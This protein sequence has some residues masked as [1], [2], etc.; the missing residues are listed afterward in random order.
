MCLIVYLNMGFALNELWKTG[1]SWVF[2]QCILYS[3]FGMRYW[4]AIYCLDILTFSGKLKRNTDYLK[5]ILWTDGTGWYHRNHFSIFT[6]SLLNHNRKPLLY[7]W[8]YIVL[9]IIWSLFLKQ[10]HCYFFFDVLL[11]ACKYE[12]LKKCVILWT[13]KCMFWLCCCYQRLWAVKVVSTAI[14]W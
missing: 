8:R 13:T 5:V 9:R 7:T 3:N 4:C 12:S 2:F 11:W 10:E 14:F 1:L 6:F